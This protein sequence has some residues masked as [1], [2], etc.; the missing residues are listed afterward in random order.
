MKLRLSELR[1]VIRQEARRLIE[2]GE[3]PRSWMRSKMAERELSADELAQEFP[4]IYQATL[5][6]MTDFGGTDEDDE[7]VAVEELWDETFTLVPSSDP[8]AQGGV[9]VGSRQ[10]LLS[11]GPMGDMVWTVDGWVSQAAVGT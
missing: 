7:D 1:R 4:D 2:V 8:R 9:D 5:D 10:R 11:S 3:H 6:E